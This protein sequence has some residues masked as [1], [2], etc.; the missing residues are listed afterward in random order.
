MVD[1]TKY[2]DPNYGKDQDM[3]EKRKLSAIVEAWSPMGLPKDYTG[4]LYSIMFIPNIGDPIKKWVYIGVK[5]SHNIND[6]Y[7]GSPT[8]PELKKLLKRKDGKL[9]FKILAVGNFSEMK[10]KEHDILTKLDAKNDP[11]FFNKHNGSTSGDSNERTEKIRA[12]YENICIAMKTDVKVYPLFKFGD[13]PNSIQVRTEFYALATTEIS[14]KINVAGHIDNTNPIVL[15]RRRNKKG[16]K[17]WVILNGHHTFD[18][19]K[20][21]NL[22]TAKFLLYYG[23]EMDTFTDTD[24]K[25]VGMKFNMPSDIIANENSAETI[26]SLIWSEYTNERITEKQLT[27]KTNEVLLEYKARIETGK[28]VKKLIKK[29]KKDARR[30]ADT[31]F[32]GCDNKYPTDPK[33]R[34]TLNSEQLRHIKYSKHYK[35]KWDNETTLYVFGSSGRDQISRINEQIWK[36]IKSGKKLERVVIVFYHPD[37][38]TA[39][40]FNFHYTENNEVSPCRDIQEMMEHFWSQDGIKII[41][42][43]SPWDRDQIQIK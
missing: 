29:W 11:R 42:D 5:Q 12:A 7:I 43:E 26:A 8:D 40:K 38:D 34:S 24:M 25:A 17:V 21:S 41:I 9:V 33:K 28:D 36:W 3:P 23:T 16:K 20:M 30:A 15:V 35:S 1:Y 6:K 32:L 19:L 22:D 37:R 4:Y 31:H 39:V 10:N 2:L 14:G 27:R 18:A 13:S